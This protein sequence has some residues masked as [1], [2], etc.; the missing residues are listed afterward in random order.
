M[1]VA[2]VADEAHAVPAAG[3]GSGP[4]AD[5]ARGPDR[6]GRPRAGGGRRLRTAAAAAAAAAPAA[7]VIA[8]AVASAGPDPAPY[9]ERGLSPG[10]LGC[11]NSYPLPHHGYEEEIRAIAA[12]GGA[13]GPIYTSAEH[14]E[15][16]Y[17]NSRD[18][19]SYLFHDVGFPGP[20]VPKG[21]DGA[22]AMMAMVT[23]INLGSAP[24]SQ[25]VWEHEY[26]AW[27]GN[28]TELDYDGSLKCYLADDPA[29]G[30][31]PYELAD[32]ETR[33]LIERAGPAPGGA[34]AFGCYSPH[35]A[36]PHL[37]VEPA[38]NGTA[39]FDYV[40][41]NTRPEVYYGW[42]GDRLE[43][44]PDGLNY[45]SGR[46]PYP[47]MFYGPDGFIPST[48]VPRPRVL[49]GAEF[50][51][52]EALHHTDGDA[53]RAVKM[54]NREFPVMNPECVREANW[55]ARGIPLSNLTYSEEH[56]CYLAPARAPDL[57]LGDPCQSWDRRN[58]DG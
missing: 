4:P 1:G 6:A 37:C 32:A 45:A 38:P 17:V 19:R 42:L 29:G 10:T 28:L 30:P 20:P 14:R 9:S 40:M 52:A 33:A 47:E 22:T 54:L 36:S 7:I 44:A 46:D 21:L 50:A 58:R 49:Y 3:R 56:R 13:P 57:P 26:I 51:V 15:Y 31:A 25:C 35:P 18:P 48:H 11:I 12:R 24:P 34:G 16:L 55:A 5:L 43:L 53:Y 23:I 27:G 41:R 39:A 8:I 2:R